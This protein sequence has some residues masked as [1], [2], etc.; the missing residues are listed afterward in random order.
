MSNKWGV[1][2]YKNK[3]ICDL[4]D[5][6]IFA[7]NNKR[8]K[9]LFELWKESNHNKFL[10]PTIDRIDNLKGYELDNIQVLTNYENSCKQTKNF[11]SIPLKDKY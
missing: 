1:L 7:N 2:H 6:V 5:F 4:S 11:L 10:R 9:L 8:L 3:S